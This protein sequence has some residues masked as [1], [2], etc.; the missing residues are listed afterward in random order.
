LD[1]LGIQEINSTTDA[2]RV[3][4]SLHL[5]NI[6]WNSSKAITTVPTSISEDTLG[7]FGVPI[8][9][10]LVPNVC[11]CTPTGE[12]QEPFKTPEDDESKVCTISFLG[13]PIQEVSQLKM[14]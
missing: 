8:I 9:A 1:P 3:R 4:E 6:L 2:I 5:D 14:N 10:V 7:T 12:T 11:T 13:L